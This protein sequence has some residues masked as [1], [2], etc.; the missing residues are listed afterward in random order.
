MDEGRERL[1]RFVAYGHGDL[2]EHTPVTKA[3]V[4][5]GGM[6][7]GDLCAA[8]IDWSD[9]TAGNLVLSVIGGPAGFTAFARSIGD[10]V[11]RLDRDEPDLNASLPGDER[12]TTTPS[13]M[14]DDLRT[15][16]LG[17]LLSAD[18]RRR[19]EAWM[20]AD[21]VGDKRLRA[22]LPR[23]WTIGDKTGSGD[24]GTN[25]IAILHPPGRLPLVASVYYTESDKPMDARNAIHREIG[26]LLA[27]T[28]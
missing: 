9:N 18:S 24:N 11:T 17:D 25:T 2:L 19:L 15:A 14:S 23:S 6:T 20:I 16:L 4:S 7:L 3:H 28:F 22:G 27:A 1:E 5:E 12:D 13:A 10:R 8:A 21:K 26:E